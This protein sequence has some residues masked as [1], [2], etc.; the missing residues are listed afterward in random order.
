[1]AYLLDVNVLIAR[2]DPRHESHAAVRAWLTAVGAE[3]LLFCPLVENGFLRIYGNPAYPEGPGSP[4]RA[5]VDL[6]D[7]RALPNA[8]FVPDDVSIDDTAL[9]ASTVDLA[10]RQLTDV[11]L[12]GL[13]V[14]KGAKFATLDGRIPA[15]AVYGGYDALT[16]IS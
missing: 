14:S 7:M 8:T 1:M 13:A 6:H 11:Y 2:T 12:L 5:A 15:N 4:G 16:V 9:F 10:P 3:K